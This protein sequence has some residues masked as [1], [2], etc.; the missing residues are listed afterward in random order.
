MDRGEAMNL[1]N[2]PLTDMELDAVSGG[3]IT[4]GS[5]FGRVGVAANAAQGGGAAEALYWLLFD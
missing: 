2:R 4:F 3:R 5:G 1:E